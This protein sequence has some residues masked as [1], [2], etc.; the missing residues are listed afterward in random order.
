MPG[1]VLEIPRLSQPL[2]L[3]ERIE[4]V[5]GEDDRAG[6]YHVRVEDF[7]N[8]GIIISTPEFIGGE[9]LL[10]DGCRV[11]IVITRQD[12]TYQSQSTIKRL[13]KGR[14]ETYLLSPPRRVTRL[15]R[16]RSVRVLASDPLTYAVIDP[17]TTW[18]DQADNAEWIKSKTI[19]ISG[20]GILMTAEEDI[21]TGD[22]LLL[23]LEL[24]R[25]LALPAVVVGSC[26]RTCRERGHLWAGVE[27]VASDMLP[28]V[29]S[30]EELHCLPA[31]VRA[32]DRAARDSLVTYIFHKQ[33]ELRQKGLL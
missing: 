15:Q 28:R 8:Q 24:F 14:N 19:D 30:R 20:H 2:K 31:P 17:A 29:F 11:T 13:S 10:R 16:R 12:A 25:E 33:I 27:F 1:V 21:E 7:L 9:T 6:H 23:R 18:K 32:F 22:R 4:L 26:A 3:W 5:V